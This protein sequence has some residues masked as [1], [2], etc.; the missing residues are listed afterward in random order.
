MEYWNV[1]KIN[2]VV[3]NTLLGWDH[4][5]EGFFNNNI[6]ATLSFTCIIFSFLFQLFSQKCIFLNIFSHLFCPSII[7]FHCCQNNSE[8]FFF[9]TFCFTFNNLKL[10]LS[11][12]HN[13]SRSIQ[14]FW[15]Q[16]SQWFLIFFP[17]FVD[18]NILCDN[19]ASIVSILCF[20]P[21]MIGGF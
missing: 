2:C 3:L 1:D 16:N 9:P 4:M 18:L 11:N 5:R 20:W 14:C 15:S 6:D 7:M 21:V 13:I 17:K 12:M 19:K 8:L 10:A